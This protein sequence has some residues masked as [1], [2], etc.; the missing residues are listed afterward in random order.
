MN[1]KKQGNAMLTEI[2]LV[3]FFFLLSCSLLLQIFFAAGRMSREAETLSDATLQAQNLADSL[4]AAADPEG[5]LEA[6][7]FASEDGETWT[8]A[9]AG[10]EMSVALRREAVAGGI[11]RH[12][13][14]TLWPLGT[15]AA[16][17]SE[18][19]AGSGREALLTLSCSRFEEAAA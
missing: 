19:A 3:I 10:F 14:V 1:G 12:Q 5:F 2:L 4:Y 13:S 11:F 9:Q 17:V 7:G 15:T 6:E 16:A 18:T 8:L